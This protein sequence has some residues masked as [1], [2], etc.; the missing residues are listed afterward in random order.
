[1]ISTKDDNGGSKKK[2]ML[3]FS[4][5]L[6][7]SSKP[8]AIA[9]AIRAEFE[10]LWSNDE[11]WDEQCEPLLANPSEAGSVSM[12]H[13][14][15]IERTLK[16]SEESEGNKLRKLASGYTHKDLWD[17]AHK[18]LRKVFDMRRGLI[19]GPKQQIAHEGATDQPK[20]GAAN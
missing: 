15:V 5:N 1:M 16:Y 17:E 6:H 13:G 9:A 2:Q 11:F 19:T 10:R 20:G 12:A 7:M 14:I 18:V 8:L 4:E 3:R